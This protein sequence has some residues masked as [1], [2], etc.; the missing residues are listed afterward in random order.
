MAYETPEC[1]YCGDGK[2]LDNDGAESKGDGDMYDVL[3]CPEHGP[4]YHHHATYCRCGCGG[5][6]LFNV[7][8]PDFIPIRWY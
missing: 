6:R 4:I 7:Y 8:D 5:G 3:S 1:P 2:P